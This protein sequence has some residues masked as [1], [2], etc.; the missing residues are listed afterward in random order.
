MTLYVFDQNKSLRTALADSR[1]YELI[2]DENNDQVTAKVAQGV[3]I[4]TGEYIGFACVDGKFRLFEADDISHD[5]DR[6]VTEIT[7][8]DAAVAELQEIIIEELQQL[9]V[10]LTDALTALLPEEW[11]VYGEDPERLEKSRAYYSTAWAMIETFRTLYEWRIIP[12]YL[13]E[14]KEITGK[15]LELQPDVATYRGRYLQS[16][17]DASKVYVTRSGRPITRLYG[18]G[19]ATGS[20]DVQTN[21]TFAEV[22]WSVANGDPVDKPKGQTWVEDPEAVA[23]HGT[24]SRTF[25]VNSAETAEELLQKTWEELQKR[26]QPTINVQAT[27]TDLE[28]IPGQSHQKIRLGDLIAVRLK[29]GETVEARIVAI[30]RN[31]TRP[32]LTTVVIGDKKATITSQVTT[33]ITNA[34]HTFE[35]LTIYKNRFREDEALIQLNAEHIQL[36]AT[37]IIEHAEQILLKADKD[38]LDSVYVLI[39]AINQDIILQAEEIALKADR[40]L[41]NGYVKIEDFETDVLSVVEDANIYNLTVTNLSAYYLNGIEATIN[42]VHASSLDVGG[43]SLDVAA[44]TM[45]DV[46]STTVWSPGADINLA[47]SH[48]VTVNS[49]GTITLGEV[50]SSGGSFKIADTQAYKDGVSAAKA[51]GYD[52]GYADAFPASVS[53]VATYDSAANAYEVTAVVKSADGTR[54]S[55]DL[56]TISA[57]AAY[58]AGYAAGYQAAKDAVVVSAGI[59]WSNPAQ[60]YA[61][62]TYWANAKVDGVT[63]DSTSG[64]E[65]K[66][67]SGYV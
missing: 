9:D 58:D 66:D 57:A 11:T 63:V 64:S 5:D 13:F 65:T 61:K 48:A 23:R 37:T 25:Y 17:V 62:V 42:A 7:A 2:H 22:E 29:T 18:L 60:Y 55:F 56:V 6:N 1:V 47:H 67:I 10:T 24:H 36:N 8:K 44:L 45:G 30:K 12:Y 33:L 16:R 34:A 14:G 59:N 38:E 40:I 41:L 15:M 4:K 20:G 35:R 51:E 46:V 43:E 3:E 32:W 21:L 49:D 31:Y 50:S 53:R 27:V 28:F 39:D 19:P 26:K 52:A 54:T